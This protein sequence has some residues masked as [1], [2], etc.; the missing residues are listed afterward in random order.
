[1]RLIIR[2]LAPIVLVLGAIGTAGGAAAAPA[3]I[4]R[5]PHFVGV[6][7]LCNGGELVWIDGTIKTVT[8]TQKDGSTLT[9]LTYHAD[10]TDGTQGNDYIANEKIQ[11][12]D[13]SDH[14]SLDIH[15]L[16]ISKGSAPNQKITHRLDITPEDIKVTDKT[17]C[18]G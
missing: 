11:I 9:N 14:Y 2:I 13:A 17:E 15:T 12:R 16:F 8:I 5:T 3:V 18:R 1:M 4:E 10:G 7:N 6:F